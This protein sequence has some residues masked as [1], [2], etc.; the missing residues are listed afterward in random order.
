MGL[1]HLWL[2]LGLLAFVAVVVLSF[3]FSEP[4]RRKRRKRKKKAAPMPESS[5]PAAPQ[6]AP[7]VLEPPDSAPPRAEQ[8]KSN[9]LEQ[10]EDSLDTIWQ[11]RLDMQFEY[12][13]R[14]SELTAR[15]VTVNRLS[16]ADTGEEYLTGFCHLREDTRHFKL[17]RVNG[18]IQI[19]DLGWTV[20][21]EDLAALLAKKQQSAAT[22]LPE[23]H[24]EDWEL[25]IFGTLESLLGVTPPENISYTREPEYGVIHQP[26]NPENWYLRLR[27]RDRAGSRR[28]F[29]IHH[30]SRPSFS[31]W[32]G[33]PYPADDK[34]LFFEVVARLS[35]QSLEVQ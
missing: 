17:S 23:P 13:N 9:A 7:P 18:A 32:E 25:D 8:P 26:G 16:I 19:P 30:F 22:D 27:C 3:L 20:Q 5:P 24:A 4:K 21:P 15:Q 34:R 10:W 14:S 28:L 11:G 1:E 33:D 29:W 31:M 35:N 12:V 2:T 6:F